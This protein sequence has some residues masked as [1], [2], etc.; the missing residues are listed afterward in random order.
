MIQIGSEIGFSDTKTITSKGAVRLTEDGE[1]NE[2]PGWPN[3]PGGIQEFCPTMM[4]AVP[5]VWDTFKKTIEETCGKSPRI[6]QWLFQVA[7]SAAY[8]ARKQGRSCPIFNFLVFR[9]ISKMIGGRLNFGISGGGP[10]S[11][12][13]QEFM[14]VIGNFPLIQGYALTESCCA[15]TVQD[16]SDPDSGNV[17]GPVGS[18]ELK[19]N[20]C[21]GPEDPGDANGDK[22]LATDDDHFGVPCLGRGEVCIRGPSMSLGYFKQPEQTAKAWDGPPGGNGWFHTGDVAYWDTRGRLHIVD[23]L[24]NLVKLKGGEYVAIEN[25]EKEYG[26]SPYVRPGITGGIMCYGDGDMRRPVAL[27]QTNMAELKKWASGQGLSGL[28]DEALCLNPEARKVV[29]ASLITA[30]GGKLGKNEGLI[31]VGLIP[32]TGPAEG[33]PSETSPWSAENGCRT[34]SGKLD[35]KGIQKAALNM[36]ESLKKEGA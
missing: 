33:A 17:G 35:R 12:D 26:T 16:V 24:K 2:E 29:L 13:V 4:V 22:Y 31:A 14:A 32:G 25:M 21:D 7:Y 30:A 18:V 34:A 20:S 3:P 23:R 8:Y 11:K 15:G 1:Y 27:V 9:K 5:V 28:T 19:L 10:I 6:V 36:M